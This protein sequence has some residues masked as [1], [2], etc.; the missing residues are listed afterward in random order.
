MTSFNSPILPPKLT[1]RCNLNNILRNRETNAERPI[2]L[3][4]AEDL[5]DVLNERT[6]IRFLGL[7]S[8]KDVKHLCCIDRITKV[9]TLLGSSVY[10]IEEV[11]FI[12]VEK[13]AERVARESN[14]KVI[15]MIKNAIEGKGVYYSEKFSLTVN[16][17][18]LFKNIQENK[19]QTNEDRFFFNGKHCKLLYEYK[20]ED[21]ITPVIFGYFE[22]K[23]FVKK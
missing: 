15:G 21:L 6:C 9:G 11:S 20:M 14:K 4:E 2:R 17:Q 23:C 8:L 1:T 5:D 18:R 13:V 16:M 22:V 7:F 3:S 19:E 10:R 12:Q